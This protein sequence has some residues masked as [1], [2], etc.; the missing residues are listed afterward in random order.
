MPLNGEVLEVVRFSDGVPAYTL[1]RFVPYSARKN[2]ALP[3]GLN[4]MV[5][6]DLS[7]DEGLLPIKGGRYW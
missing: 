7:F 5:E 3:E 6:T 1:I 2:E 4:Y